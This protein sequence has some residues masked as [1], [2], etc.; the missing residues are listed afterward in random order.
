MPFYRITITLSN[1]T[2]KGI[3][4]LDNKDLDDVWLIFKGLAEQEYGQQKILDFEVVM[5]SIYSDDYRN[6]KLKESKS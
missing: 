1:K 5:V 6:W 4:E 2:I 3:R